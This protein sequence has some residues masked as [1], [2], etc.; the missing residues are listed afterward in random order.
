MNQA[1]FENLMKFWRHALE[2]EHKNL[3][4]P[5]TASC[6][7]FDD[8][9]SYAEG[10]FDAIQQNHVMTCSHCRTLVQLF[11]E[12]LEAK[13]P[14]IM[15]T[16]LAWRKTISAK[17]REQWQGLWGEGLWAIPRPVLIGISLAFVVALFFLL[18]PHQE[19]TL[20]EL[21]SIEAVPYQA[22]QI[23][24]GASTGE[25]ERLFEEGMAFYVQ[26]DYSS[27]ITKLALAAQQDSANAG[28]HF[29]LGLCYLLADRVDPAIAHLQRTT[30]LGG[31][32][33]LEKAYWY[34][35]NA[36]LLKGERD[37]AFRAFRKVVEM[38]GDYQWEAQEIIGKIERLSRQ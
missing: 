29:Y 11:K 24:S 33:V 8:L 21:A 28:F 32:S 30:A 15:E 17:I 38:E 36:W 22:L 18:L 19:K 10:H 20:A 23:R 13:P 9:K 3:P 35:G 16:L 27:A 4:S 37:F 25:A 2:E 5:K 26:K 12:H 6:L 7:S 14:T 1:T 34:L 31:N